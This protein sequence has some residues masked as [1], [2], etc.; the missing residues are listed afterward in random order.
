M[1]LLVAE[2]P[3]PLSQGYPSEGRPVSMNSGLMWEKPT[4]EG[5]AEVV[6]SLLDVV[7]QSAPSEKDIE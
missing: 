5:S 4:L 3:V 6:P 1:L 7:L 2:H